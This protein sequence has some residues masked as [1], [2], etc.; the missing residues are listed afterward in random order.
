MAK[1]CPF[2]P[3]VIYYDSVHVRNVSSVVAVVGRPH[4]SSS[5]MLSLPILNALSIF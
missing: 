2:M 4:L 1:L 3:S 5:L